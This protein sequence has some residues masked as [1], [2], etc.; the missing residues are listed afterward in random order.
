MERMQ[1]KQFDQ[2]FKDKVG[3]FEP[4]V[5][6][7]IWENIQQ[8]LDPGPTVVLHKKRRNVWWI[9]VAAAVVLVVG[10]IMF[11]INRPTE[12]V[13]LTA[14]KVQQQ[15][16]PH[17]GKGV[18]SAEPVA[19]EKRSHAT[20]NKESSRVVEQVSKARKESAMPKQ[21]AQQSDAGIKASFD[22]AIPMSEAVKITH[23]MMADEIKTADLAAIDME[24][25]PAQHEM[26]QREPFEDTVPGGPM[27]RIKNKKELAAGDIL[28]YVASSVSPRNEKIISFASDEEGTIKVAVNFKALKIRL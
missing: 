20:N 3:R 5:P 27:K 6:G 28:E 26:A 19:K 9:Q 23:P 14:K 24:T 11:Y 7:H 4:P 15:E 13:Y 2:F 12:V 17:Q 8:Q 21:M 18:V 25:M 1:D 16:M 22:D 10:A